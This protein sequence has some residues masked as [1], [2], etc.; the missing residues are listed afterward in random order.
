M[1]PC[2]RSSFLTSTC[3][4]ISASSTQPD[5]GQIM[6]APQ[7]LC[8]TRDLIEPA[9]AKIATDR[10]PILNGGFHRGN[11]KNDPYPGKQA[12]NQH[13]AGYLLLPAPLPPR[14]TESTTATASIYPRLLRPHPECCFAEFEQDHPPNSSDRHCAQPSLPSPEIS[15]AFE[16]HAIMIAQSPHKGRGEVRTTSRPSCRRSSILPPSPAAPTAANISPAPS[17]SAACRP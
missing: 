10:Q 14:F 9:L 8:F 7:Q 1:M 11:G 15:Q 3:R 13:A 5:H 2:S 6:P 17:R 16:N 12:A 4:L